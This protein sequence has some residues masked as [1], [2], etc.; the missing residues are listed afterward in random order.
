MS[1]NSG[2]TPFAEQNPRSDDGL[3]PLGIRH[4][5]IFTTGI[6]AALAIISPIAQTLQPRQSAFE[7]ILI[8]IYSLP[9]GLSMGFL[10]WVAV[11]A[12]QKKSLP[13]TDPGGKFAI[14]LSGLRVVS[15]T[16][17]LMELGL[18]DLNDSDLTVPLRWF[19]WFGRFA[20]FIVWAT[21]GIQWI[22][23]PAWR[24]V[25]IAQAVGVLFCLFP[26]SWAFGGAALVYA[27]V[28]DKRAK[29][30]RHWTHYFG[31]LL[32]SLSQFAFF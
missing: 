17:S 15:T 30:A 26:I 5:L 10:G 31:M 3:P 32:W 7:S 22:K 13:V 14:L 27:Y 9:I 19:P 2:D 25:I 21:I 23:D 28:Q 8:F 24:I 20:I 1:E 18:F 29:Q 12:S 6:A 4:I 11:R 16:L